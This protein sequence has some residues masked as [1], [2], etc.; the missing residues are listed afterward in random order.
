MITSL[1]YKIYGKLYSFHI[2]SL[3]FTGTRR[4]FISAISLVFFFLNP[5][6]ILSARVNKKCEKRILLTS[7]QRWSFLGHHNISFPP[8]INNL[9]T[10]RNTTKTKDDIIC[11]SWTPEITWSTKRETVRESRARIE[12][13]HAVLDSLIKGKPP[14]NSPFLSFIYSRPINT[15][16]H[17]FTKHASWNVNKHPR[18]SPKSQHADTI[19]YKIRVRNL[20]KSFLVDD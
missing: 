2:L 3:F 18:S 14:L 11:C 15:F 7:S 19:N 9:N 12:K 16:C 8:Q 13:A 5:L 6:F 4:C 17:R 20:Q 1:K 10:L